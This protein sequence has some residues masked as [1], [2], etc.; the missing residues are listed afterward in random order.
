MR[1]KF[2]CIV[3]AAIILVSGIIATYSYSAVRNTTV[4]EAKAPISL[5]DFWETEGL[6]NTNVLQFVTGLKV[7]LP[8]EWAGK[9][10]FDTDI[11]PEHEPYINTLIVYENTNYA[12][13][14]CGVLF[15]LELF[16]YEKGYMSY[17]MSNVLGVYKQ[18]DSEYVLTYMEP[19]D[20][21]YIEGDEEK[22]AAYKELFSHIDK[23]QIV[24]QNMA[25]F[26]PCTI[27]DLE[28]LRDEGELD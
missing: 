9:I 23:I 12:A 15:Y 20:L 25:G 3:I 26:T 21:Q 14:Q 5:E 27:D 10:V 16:K 7:V 22:K 19:R 13:Q 28:W 8:E 1:K 24:T 11:G 2:S 4:K 18:G 17:T 6:E